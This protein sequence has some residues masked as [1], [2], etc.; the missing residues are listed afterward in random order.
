MKKG[1]NTSR[2]HIQ[3]CKIMTLHSNK[4]P[5]CNKICYSFYE[6]DIY[7]SKDIKSKRLSVHFVA[8]VSVIILSIKIFFE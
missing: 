8:L 5:Y 3:V 1:Y 2:N 6:K 7:K 4:M